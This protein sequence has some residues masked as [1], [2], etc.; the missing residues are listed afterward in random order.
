MRAIIVGGIAAFV[1]FHGPNGDMIA[2]DPADGQL[3]VR[4]VPPNV[5]MQ[6]KTLIQTGAGTALVIESPCV[7]LHA[8][9]RRCQ[10]DMKKE[11]PK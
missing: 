2:I 1:I 8:L 10:M 11:V 4:P 3:I 5:G 9:E 7:V 6:G